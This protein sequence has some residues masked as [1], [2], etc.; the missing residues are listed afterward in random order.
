MKEKLADVVGFSDFARISFKNLLVNHSMAAL[1]RNVEG[2]IY[3]NAERIESVYS[4]IKEHKAQLDWLSPK[5]ED[6]MEKMYR[7][8]E[9]IVKGAGKKCQE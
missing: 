2:F 5:M 7:Q 6:I 1:G 9:C 4:I 3:D 8:Y